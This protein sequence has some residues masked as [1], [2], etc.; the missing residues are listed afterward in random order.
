MAAEGVQAGQCGA[1][2]GRGMAGVFKA[3][4][5]SSRAWPQP[6]SRGARFAIISI[7]TTS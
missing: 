7:I 1:G 2:R 6:S 4:G 3:H 5:L